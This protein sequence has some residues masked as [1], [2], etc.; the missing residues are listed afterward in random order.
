MGGGAGTV[1]GMASVHFRAGVAIVVRRP[2]TG[3]VL[4]FE[5]ADTPGAWQLP[6]GGLQDG[7]TP[8]QGA[9]RELEEETGLCEGDVEFVSEHP[10]WLVYEWPVEVQRSKG[11]IHRRIGQ[12][13]R[14]FIFHPLDNDL[15]PIPDGREFVAWMWVQPQWLI[16]HVADWRR[17]PYQAVLGHL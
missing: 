14:W 12:A 1:A 3:E 11:G 4:A 2:D 13:Q 6:Q 10:E 16:D 17:A 15:L 5:R 7:E 8:L 9:W